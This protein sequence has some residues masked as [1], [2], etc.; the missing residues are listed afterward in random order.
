MPDGT[1]QG[2]HKIRHVV[3]IMQENR[4]FDSYF[5]TYPKADG[6]PGLAGH[7]GT[8]PCVPDPSRHRCIR[9]YHDTS[10]TNYGGPHGHNNAM[11]DI[12]GGA[13]NG[14]IG[15][16]EAG[17]K[18][19]CAHFAVPWCA[20]HTK[21]PDVMGYHDAHEI[22]NYWSYAR[23]FT[24]QDHMF[25]S[26][27]SWSL[28]EHLYLV[29]GWSAH[30]ATKD[31]PMSCS[32]AV[33]NPT[34]P[35]HTV[36]NP[37]GPAPNYAWT[38][39]TYL[40]HA[41]GVSWRYYIQAGGQP[42]CPDDQMFCT[43]VPQNSWTP[44]IWNPLPW[45]DTVQKDG[46]TS[47]VEGL[48]HLFQALSTNSL[49]AV[50]WIVP[51]N[52]DSEHPPSRVSVGQTYV[53]GLI[54]SIMR[55]SSWSSTAIF[56]GWDDWGGFYDHVKPPSVDGQG[57][58]MRVPA[59][60]ISPYARRGYVDHQVLSQDAYLKFIEDD[61]LYGQ[62]INPATD[63]RPDT[64]PDVREN[65]AILGNLAHDFNFDQKPLAPVILPLNPPFS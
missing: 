12:A 1:P 26:D 59:M 34:W 9:P 63:G 10:D 6:I 17:K 27:M 42:D 30:C 60:V 38:D 3:I 58:G 64:R 47:N 61:F 8:V 35:L 50:S 21:R 41:Y 44:G 19:S 18:K 31:D 51:G 16:A 46:Q 22:P 5:G 43:T 23:H 11:A 36:G 29:S 55:S 37:H 49:P 62:R 57:Y 25:E 14:F 65:A 52:K 45:F 4:S 20:T 28:P 32:G 40:L 54:N 15:Q 53:T 56:L 39:I 7:P 33:E 13:M 48:S 24:L 2:I